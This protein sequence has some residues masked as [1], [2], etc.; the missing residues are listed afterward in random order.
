MMICPKIFIV[1]ICRESGMDENKSNNDSSIY[2]KSDHQLAMF[3]Q[4]SNKRKQHKDAGFVMIWS[5]TKGNKVPDLPLL[6]KCWEEVMTLNYNLTDMLMIL[7]Q[8]LSTQSEWYCLEYNTT[9]PYGIW[10]EKSN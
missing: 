7:S 9:A 1:D 2:N 6:S 8:K 5:T 4:L 10:F 3:R